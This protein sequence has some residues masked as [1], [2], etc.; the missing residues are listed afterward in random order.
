MFKKIGIVFLFIVM[1]LGITSTCIMAKTADN[2]IASKD[3]REDDKKAIN[4][5]FDILKKVKSL[6]EVSE[7]DREKISQYLGIDFQ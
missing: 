4:E 7:S 3:S 2:Q 1:T 6:E 5:I